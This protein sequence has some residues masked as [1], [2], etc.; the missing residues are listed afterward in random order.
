MQCRTILVL[1]INGIG[2]SL[3]DNTYQASI[4]AALSYNSRL[5]PLQIFYGTNTPP[6]LTGSVC[7]G[8]VGNIM[9]RVYHFGLGTNDNGNVQSIDNCRDTTRTLNYTYDAL[10]R[11]TQGNS[12]GPEF[13][14]T[15]VVDA[16]GN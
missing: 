4:K 16:W 1:L 9:H 7:P 11:V 6:V 5:Q 10:N 12:T 3:F 15:Y 14:D 8:T 2:V 13:G